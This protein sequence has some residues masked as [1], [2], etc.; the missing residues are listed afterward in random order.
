LVRVVWQLTRNQRAAVAI[1]LLLVVPLSVCEDKQAEGEA[2]LDRARAASNIRAPN[3]PAFR[4]RV[5]YSFVSEKLETV[6]G[7]YSE[8]WVSRNQWRREIVAGDSRRI[9]IGG[10][11]KRWLLDTGPSLPEQ[12]KR[13][14]RSLDPVPSKASKFVFDS[15]L[16]PAPNDPKVACA[17]SVPGREKQKSAF[18]F[19]KESGVLIQKVEPYLVGRRMA[20]Y[21]CDY[22]AFRIFGNYA[23]PREMACFVEGHQKMDAKVTELALEASPDLALF[24]PSPEAVELGDCSEKT[25]PARVI[26][27]PDPALPWRAA[28]DSNV[29]LELIVTTKGT[30][31]DVKVLRSGGKSFDENAV[32]AV[33]GWHFQPATCDGIPMATMISVEVNFRMGR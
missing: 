29:T 21:S 18:C 27:S 16:D 9:E 8:W 3:A 2:M 22:A 10:P 28:N 25:T 32:R 13:L 19:H 31:Q 12:V 4:L 15:I 33:R 24:K 20:G 26:S 6:T 1:L 17:I 11:D 23:Y 7:T 14:P 5:T 30:P